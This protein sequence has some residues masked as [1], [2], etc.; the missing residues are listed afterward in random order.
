MQETKTVYEIEIAGLPL[1]LR[2]SHDEKTVKELSRMVDSKVNEALN[3]GQNVSFQNALLLS[4]LHIAEELVLLKR[5]AAS[6]LG[7]IEKQAQS[8]LSGL[9]SSPIS[10]MRLDI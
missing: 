1:K 6:E 5:A 7:Q 4:A 10:R 2:S 8:I 9:E 3:M